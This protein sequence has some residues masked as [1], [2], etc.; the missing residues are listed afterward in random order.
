MK[1]LEIGRPISAEEQD[2]D[3]TTRHMNLSRVTR[4]SKSMRLLR[5]II[6]H[7][8]QF[9]HAELK[10]RAYGRE[11]G[12]SAHGFFSAFRHFGLAT[13]IRAGRK[14][15]WAPTVKGIMFYKVLPA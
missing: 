12:E 9:T 3:N 8:R 5:E 15:L 14:V 1:M 11:M 6:T 4:R 13:F 2:V 10:R 7:P